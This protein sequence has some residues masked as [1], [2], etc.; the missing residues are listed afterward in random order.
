MKRIMLPVILLLLIGAAIN[1]SLAVYLGVR[2]RWPGMGRLELSGT[3][4][5]AAEMQPLWDRH[6]PAT[7]RAS[8]LTLNGWRDQRFGVTTRGL[9]NGYVPLNNSVNG[10]WSGDADAAI[11]A[12]VD[13]GWPL[14]SIRRVDTTIAVTN[15]TLLQGG[16]RNDLSEWLRMAKVD[17]SG[18]AA[19][20]LFWA[21]A[22]WIPWAIALMVRRSWRASR[23]QCS[24]CGYPIGI[25]PVCTECGRPVDCRAPVAI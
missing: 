7:V 2:Y 24:A 11:I 13:C 9:G 3:K 12:I 5:S 14:R 22:S 16:G 17:W 10:A 6:A 23:N 21:I 20:A 8:N 25:S 1:F 18:S 19:N 4:L 15:R